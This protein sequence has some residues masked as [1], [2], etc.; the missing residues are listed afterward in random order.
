MLLGS[1]AALIASHVHAA[2]WSLFGP[3]APD[4]EFHGFASQGFLGSTSYNYLGNSKTGSLEFTEF[5]LNASFNPFPR[6]RITAQAF[7]YDVGDAGKYD[8][9]LDYALAEYTFNDYIGIR[10]GRIRRPQGIYNDIQD[11]DLGRTSI[12][13]PQGVYDARYRDFYES[14]DGGELF[15]TLPLGQA[16]SLAYE[17]Y[18][19]LIRPTPDGGL[20][21]QIQNGLPPGGHLDEIDSAKIFGGQLWWSTP[22]DGLRLGASGA[23]AAAFDFNTTLETAREPVHLNERSNTLLQQYSAEYLW[24]SWTFQTEALIRNTESETPGVS[25]LGIFS[26]YAGA[27]YRFNKWIEVGGYYTQYFDY[28]NGPD[29]AGVITPSDAYQKDAAVSLRFDLT[30]RWI[31]KV[32]GHYLHGTALL[33]DDSTNPVRGDNGWWMIAVKTTISF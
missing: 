21:L 31:F 30:Q 1:L 15:G 19:G 16:G 23:Y 29:V 33:E 14:L 26:W 17:L 3:N 9:V 11:V 4:I 7:S 22:I 13:L 24:K 32:E 6:T 18:A 10:A 25:D 27:A 8:A 5:G 12:L 20:A 2:D 28:N